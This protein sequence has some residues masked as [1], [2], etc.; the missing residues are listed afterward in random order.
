MKVTIK[1]LK[2]IQILKDPKQVYIA[3]P[4]NILAQHRYRKIDK[5]FKN[6]VQMRTAT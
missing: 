2:A 1:K 3:K 6:R 4:Q 5:L